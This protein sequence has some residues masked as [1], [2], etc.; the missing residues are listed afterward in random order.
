M[1][2]ATEEI[3]AEIERTVCQPSDLYNKVWILENIVHHTTN[4]PLE[5]R[6]FLDWLLETLKAADKLE[7]D[8][9]PDSEQSN[10]W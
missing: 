8:N 5:T 4:L 2:N 1:S 7:K 10:K 3:I 6:N 9:I